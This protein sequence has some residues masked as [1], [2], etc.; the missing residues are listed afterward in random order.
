MNSH[1]RFALPAFFLAA[2]MAW[3]TPPGFAQTSTAPAQTD[4]DHS[5]HHPEGVQGGMPGS[6]PFQGGQ[7]GMMGGGM[8]EMTPMMHGMMADQG[9]PMFD[10]AEGRLA[11]LKTELKITDAQ[12]PQWNRFADALR[13]TA[14][15][16]KVMHQ[17]MMEGD[18]P[19]TALARL[20]LQEKLVAE[21][22][23]VL[24]TMKAALGTLYASFSDEQKQLADELMVGPMGMM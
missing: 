19:T 10:H 16:M 5:A 24:K 20:E 13:S 23:E 15:A 21:R 22:L 1:A 8:G 3:M 4:Q 7:S 12:M 17:Q 14:G 11:F 2:A 9:F 18:M 6:M